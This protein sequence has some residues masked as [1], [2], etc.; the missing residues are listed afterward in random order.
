MFSRVQR[1]LRQGEIGTFLEKME[2]RKMKNEQETR[3][4]LEVVGD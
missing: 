4:T 2:K 1:T 3:K